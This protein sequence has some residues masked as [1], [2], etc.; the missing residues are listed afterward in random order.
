MAKKNMNADDF[1]KKHGKPERIA[2][3]HG[4]GKHTI[5]VSA[6]GRH[7]SQSFDNA[8][9]A[10]A[11]HDALLSKFSPA[12]KLSK[13]SGGK[14]QATNVKREN[15]GEGQQGAESES[16]EYEMPDLTI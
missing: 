14:R 15:P 5:T 16:R 3:F 8:S 10:K 2:V 1:F 13:E 12:E 6:K 11:V 9:E 7:L 4:N